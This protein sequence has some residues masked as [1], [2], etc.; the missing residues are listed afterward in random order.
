MRFSES[1]HF[2]VAQE[3]EQPVI[4]EFVGDDG[5]ELL[6]GRRLGHIARRA[7][8]TIGLWRVGAP[9]RDGVRALRPSL[10]T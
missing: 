10:L 8:D 9:L 2:D 4:G 7:N 1:T 6:R 5:F 3:V